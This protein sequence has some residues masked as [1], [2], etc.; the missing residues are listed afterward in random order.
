VQQP[1]AR[2][3]DVVAGRYEVLRLIGRGGMADVFEARDRQVER[4][5][6]LK[7]LRAT[8]A[9]N[10]EA[11]ARFT[12]EART[13]EAVGHRNVAVMHDAGF[14]KNVPYLAMELLGGRSMAHL[15][16]ER[17]TVESLRAAVYGYQTLQ[18]L[19]ATHAVGV[20]HRDLKPGNLMLE[21]STGR[22]ERVVLI[23]FGFAALGGATGLTRQGVVVGSPSYMAP[24]RLKGEKIDARSDL[25]S[26]GAI[27]Y[28]LL[29]GR[30]PFLGD[31]GEVLRKHV[32]EAPTPPSELMPDV[33]PEIDAV[34]LR[35]LAK[36]PDDRA[37]S[38][39]A[40]AE[41]LERAMQKR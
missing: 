19:A 11:R 40:M 16:H 37:P 38:A 39:T 14:D 27:L 6:A 3:G 8:L 1:A 22:F 10:H 31:P 30:C 9:M 36:N 12:H 26:V 7:L 2:Q 33:P 17:K 35:A 41:E 20:L 24:E 25:Y 4:L 29:T 21:P 23:D 28:E 32:G 18:G 15:L 5:V 34:V 13:Q